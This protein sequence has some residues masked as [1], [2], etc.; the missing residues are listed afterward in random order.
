[1]DKSDTGSFINPPS[2]TANPEL[3]MAYLDAMQTLN[4]PKTLSQIKAEGE[5][6]LRIGAIWLVGVVSGILL[7]GGILSFFF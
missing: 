2:S 3:Y 6:K 5:I 1:M 7:S 4:K